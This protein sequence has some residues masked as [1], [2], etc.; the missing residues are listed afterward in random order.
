MLKDP[1]VYCQEELDDLATSLPN[2]MEC[3]T[4]TK[5]TYDNFVMGQLV[6]VEALDENTSEQYTAYFAVTFT[7]ADR[8][9]TLVSAVQLES[10]GQFEDTVIEEALNST[11]R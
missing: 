1:Q 8:G 7:L 9:Y 10:D 6:E 5:S 3:G 2:L 4:I 11:Q